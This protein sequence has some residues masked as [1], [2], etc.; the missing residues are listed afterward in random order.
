MGWSL[1]QRIC[2]QVFPPQQRLCSHSTVCAPVPYP[3]YSPDLV[4]AT[5]FQMKRYM[6]GRSFRA[7]AEAKEK[8]VLNNG[9]LLGTL[10]YVISESGHKRFSVSVLFH[11]G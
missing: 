7:E 9:F 4:P 11:V 5:S 6:K 2:T 8:N 1:V 10:S 3:P